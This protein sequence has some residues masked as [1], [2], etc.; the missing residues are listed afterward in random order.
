[1]HGALMTEHDRHR[2]GG[3]RSIT[4]RS[5]W[6]SPDAMMRTSTSAAS[7]ASM[8]MR[9]ISSGCLTPGRMAAS[10]LIIAERYPEGTIRIIGGVMPVQT[11]GPMGQETQ[12][13]WV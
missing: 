7:S 11:W 13:T 6:Q 2:I 5:V 10:D 4:S 9:R 3:A 1:M 12:G 8:H